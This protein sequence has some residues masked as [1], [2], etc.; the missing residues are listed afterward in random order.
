MSQG[1]VDVAVPLVT[2][3]LMVAVGLDLTAAEFQRVRRRPVVLLA[4]LLAPVVVLPPLAWAVVTLSNP[5]SAVAT[6]LL[7][8]AAC[9]I[10]GISNV[11]SLLA[12]ADTALSVTLTTLSCL[13]AVVTIPM[14]SG[15]LAAATGRDLAFAVPGR[16]LIAQLML[17]LAAPVLLGMF[18]RARW[19]GFASRRRSAVQRLAFTLVA[20]LVVVVV[21]SQF[22][23]FLRELTAIVPRALL[24][25][26]LSLGAGA[27]VGGLVRADRREMVTL[28]LEF[29]TRNVAVAT[30]I[31]VTILG[32]TEFAVFGATY[33]LAEL[34]LILLIVAAL[35]QHRSAPS[36]VA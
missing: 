31:S 10:G 25:L 5:S 20:L 1:V 11:Y 23:L 34:P 19:P 21:S 18:V 6:G 26:L 29:G 15:G 32:R 7:I 36:P 4:G 2:F 33:F 30:A 3:L 8:M 16:L 22:D 9:P 27:F 14:I 13:L 17:M 35:R 12:R 28:A 24:F